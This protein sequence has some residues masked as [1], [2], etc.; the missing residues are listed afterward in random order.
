M[1]LEVLK[2]PGFHW[3]QLVLQHL[4][5]QE[6]RRVQKPLVCPYFLAARPGLSLPGLRMAH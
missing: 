6:I 2:H 1:V 3:A 4:G 5:F